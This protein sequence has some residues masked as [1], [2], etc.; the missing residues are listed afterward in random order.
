MH[1]FNKNILKL[2]QR[3]IH[4]LKKALPVAWFLAIV[5]LIGGFQSLAASEPLDAKHGTGLRTLSKEQLQEIEQTWPRIVGVR[6]N[7]IGV[8]RIQEHLQKKGYAAEEDLVAA[9]PNEELVTVVGNP[10]A[11]EEKNAVSPAA[12]PTSINNSTLP[13]FPP[14][15]DQQSEGSCVG[16]GSTY[17]QASH[18]IG[19]LNGYNNK[20]SNAH[21]LSPRW[22]YNLLN[23]GYDQGLYVSSAFSLLAQNGAPSIAS[24]PY[25]NGDYRSWDLNSQDWINALNNRMA[26]AQYISG[27]GGSSQNLQTI[28]Q[29]LTNGHVLTFATYIYSWVFNKV[30]PD[31]ANPNSPYVGQ[32]ACTYMSGTSGGHFVTIV[33]YDDTIWIDVNGNGQVD[34]G[35]RGAFLIANSWGSGW[36]NAGFTWISYDAF[37]NQSAVV[38]GP[39]NRVPA[40]QDNYVYCLLPKA[41]NYSPSLVGQFSLSQNYRNQIFIQAGLSSTSQTTPSQTF[42]CYALQNQGG[43]FMFDGSAP[44]NAETAIFAVDMSDFGTS[45]A[46]QRYYLVTADTQA[47]NPTTLNSFSLIDLAHNKQVNYP[48]TPVNCDN[49]EITPF[50]DYTFTNTTDTTPPVVN[51]TSPVNNSAVQ[52]SINVSVNATDNVAVAKVQLAVDG[53]LQATDTVAPYLFTIDTTKWGDGSHSL[54]ATAYDTSGNSSETAVTINVV[55]GFTPIYVNCGGGEVMYQGTD[56]KPDSGFSGTS[57]TYT[58]TNVQNVNP[59]YDTSRYGPNFS[60]KFSVPNGN[61]F[62]KLKLIETYFSQAGARIFSATINGSAVITNLDLFQAAGFCTPHDLQFPVTV[63]NGKINIHLVSSVDNA[64]ISGI[65]ILTR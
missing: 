10:L 40:S 50:I 17:Y 11:A 46:A 22:T 7:K 60:Y 56:F 14:I 53:V 26:P 61:Y 16:F 55:N 54:M 65:R 34:A 27:V 62:V 59:I 58:S 47:G 45:S 20:T 57:Y 12:L 1:S 39:T 25:V 49:S 6:P 42:A 43:P 48:N 35:E 32:Q 13:S 15:G 5:S 19:L 64:T 37:L 31:P 28:K 51:I 52:N 8:A 38:N 41:A 44:G 21:I 24:F 30:L 2:L 63:T 23:G 33:G 18:E 36:G 4:S 29:L 3:K 9:N